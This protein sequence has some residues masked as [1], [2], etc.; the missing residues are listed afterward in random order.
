[1]RIFD[2]LHEL[3][4]NSGVIRQTEFF[5]YS[6]KDREALE[7]CLAKAYRYPDVTT[8]IRAKKKD[9]NLVKEIGIKETGILVSCSDYHIF[10]KLN[11]TRKQSIEM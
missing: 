10:K 3:D 7:K 5:L 6:K 9:F 1:V 11:L 4:N 2:Y 8:W